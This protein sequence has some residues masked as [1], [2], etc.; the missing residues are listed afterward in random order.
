[1]NV[2]FFQSIY[3]FPLIRA[4]DLK[5]IIDAH[6]RVEFTK[7]SFFLK[8]GKMANEYYL[9]EKGLLRAY[10]YDFKGNDITTD[11]YST[12]DISIEVSSPPTAA[13]L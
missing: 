11:F 9:I 13:S 12:N 5:E 1:M 10:V 8:K 6:E 2:D 3:N 7:G 4:S